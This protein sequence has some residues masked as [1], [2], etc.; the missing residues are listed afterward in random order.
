MSAKANIDGKGTEPVA[1]VD[2]S[3]NRIY[4]DRLPQIKGVTPFSVSATG[5]VFTGAL[6][7]SKAMAS[8]SAGAVL[9]IYDNTSAFGTAIFSHTFPAAG[10]FT[11]PTLENVDFAVGAWAVITGTIDLELSTL[12][13]NV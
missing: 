6:R 5:Q 10:T 9:T 12:D 2:S 1:L 7:I 8:V 4:L 13:P 3:G 11:L